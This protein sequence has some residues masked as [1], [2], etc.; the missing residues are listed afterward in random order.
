VVDY[1]TQ[2]GYATIVVREVAQV[3][4]QGWSLEGKADARRFSAFADENGQI[5]YVRVR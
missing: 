4:G 3:P 2:S 5:V 1:L